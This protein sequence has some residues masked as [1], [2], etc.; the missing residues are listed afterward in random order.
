[1]IKGHRGGIREQRS[2][3]LGPVCFAFGYPGPRE[4]FV[5]KVISK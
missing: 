4:T 1:M 2:E 3:P 5:L